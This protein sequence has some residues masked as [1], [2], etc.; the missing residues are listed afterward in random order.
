MRISTSHPPILLLH[1]FKG[2]LSH[3]QTKLL[4]LLTAEIISTLEIASLTGSSSHEELNWPVVRFGAIIQ[5]QP[6]PWDECEIYFAAAD[7]S[8][9]L[10]SESLRLQCYTFLFVPDLPQ[11][12]SLRPQ[13]EAM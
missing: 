5:L 8:L 1:D 10:F 4:C 2:I 13:R 6:L 11:T 7:G 3:N 9:Y 12:E